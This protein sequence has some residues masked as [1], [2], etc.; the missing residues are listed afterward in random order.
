MMSLVLPGRRRMPKPVVEPSRHLAP[1]T[2]THVHS[3]SGALTTGPVHAG[4]TDGAHVTKPPAP[5]VPPPFPP[6]PDV[7]GAPLPA[8]PAFVPEPFVPVM[9]PPEPPLP[10]SVEEASAALS[11]PLPHPVWIATT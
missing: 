1:G 8:L 11:P 2:G 4:S 10:T 9:K 3:E 6:D 7:D 5:P